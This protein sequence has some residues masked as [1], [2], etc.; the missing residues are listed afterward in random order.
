MPNF[1]T[2]EKSVSQIT[3]DPRPSGTVAVYLVE[4]S[5]DEE[6]NSLRKLFGDLQG[7]VNI[8]Q[9]SKGRLVSY[10]VQTA[11]ADPS[12]LDELEDVLKSSY[13]FVITQRSFDGVIYRIVKELCSDT[14]SKLMSVSRC[15]ICGKL[16]PFPDTVVT[17]A[18]ADGHA[19]ASRI[20]CGTCTASLVVRTNKDFVRS[21]LSADRHD[22]GLLES[23]ELTR[24]RGRASNLRYKVGVRAEA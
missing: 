14:G 7:H 19:I 9:L 13:P 12:V 2:D 8:K 17:L 22:F 4:V 16:E 10:A 20:Y 18:D 23:S 11:D 24:S 15:N 21:L 1:R 3:V 5:N 6:A